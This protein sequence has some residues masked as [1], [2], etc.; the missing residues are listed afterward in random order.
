M[1]EKTKKK[2]PIHFNVSVKYHIFVKLVSG[3]LELCYNNN[4]NILLFFLKNPPWLLCSK[5]ALCTSLLAPMTI[6]V[7]LL[8]ALHG[9]LLTDFLLQTFF[10]KTFSF[11]VCMSLCCWVLILILLW[12]QYG[13]H[14]SCFIILISLL[15]QIVQF[16]EVSIL[17]F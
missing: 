10:F 17:Y 16:L 9:W 4:L 3:C 2:K 14:S 13:L 1:W 12:W 8:C 11:I 7:V 5:L 6:S 15:W